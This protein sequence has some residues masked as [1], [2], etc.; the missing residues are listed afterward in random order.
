MVSIVQNFLHSSPFAHL[1]PAL[2]TLPRHPL[3]YLSDTLGVLRMH[4]DYQTELSA[5]R[6]R[7]AIL[8]T[9]KQRLYRRAHGIEDLD[10]EEES[11]VDVRGLVPWDDGLTKKEREMGGRSEELTHKMAHEVQMRDGQGGWVRVADVLEKEMKEQRMAEEN[12]Q[13]DG[14]VVVAG[15]E[16][17]PA[18]RIPPRQPQEQEQSQQEPA[19]RR[20]RPRYFGIW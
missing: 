14:R 2:S 4:Q 5:A 13:E 18:E 3:A 10:A 6:R 17:G 1:L 15:E 11:G 12:S 16:E 20:K 19:V 8:D 9:Q 7:A